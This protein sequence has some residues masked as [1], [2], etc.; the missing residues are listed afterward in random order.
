[1]D[2]WIE[3]PVRRVFTELV[4]MIVDMME[5]FDQNAIHQDSIAIERPEQRV[6]TESVCM[7][8]NMTDRLT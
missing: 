2:E 4:R 6:F 5:D 8:V 7:I 1:M 3:S